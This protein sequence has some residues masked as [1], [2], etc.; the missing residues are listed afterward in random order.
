MLSKKRA[1]LIERPLSAAEAAGFLAVLQQQDAE[2]FLTVSDDVLEQAGAKRWEGATAE[3][4]KAA[5]QRLLDAVN[6][7]GHQSIKKDTVAGF[8]YYKG[9]PTWYYHKFRVNFALQQAYQRIEQ[10][11]KMSAAYGQLTVY[12]NQP[13][14][15]LLCLLI[16]DVTFVTAEDMLKQAAPKKKK[17]QNCCTYAAIAND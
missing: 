6:A 13:P 15:P 10:Y 8:L 4:T 1:Y 16:R 11:Q 3:N 12:T 14:A 2:V 9:F 7:L 5:N 17:K